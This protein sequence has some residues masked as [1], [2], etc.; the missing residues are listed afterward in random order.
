[1]ELALRYMAEQDMLPRPLTV[2]EVWD[3]LPEGIE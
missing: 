2:D 1:M 3:G